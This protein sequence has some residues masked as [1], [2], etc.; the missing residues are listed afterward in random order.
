VTPKPKTREEKWNVFL[1]QP[2][3]AKLVDCFCK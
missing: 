3:E 1:S 2:S